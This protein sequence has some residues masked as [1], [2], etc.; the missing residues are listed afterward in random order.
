MRGN[1]LTEGIKLQHKEWT[2]TYCRSF[3]ILLHSQ[4]QHLPLS[5]IIMKNLVHK[6]DQGA[7]GIQCLCTATD[8]T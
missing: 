2:F 5:P 1:C 4:I 8:T 3:L 6:D 7:A